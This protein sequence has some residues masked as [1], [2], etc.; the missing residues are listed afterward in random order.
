MPNVRTF[1]RSSGKRMVSSPPPLGAS[2]YHVRRCSTRCGVS[3]SARCA[4]QTI[5][6]GTYPPQPSGMTLGGTMRT[7]LLVDDDEFVL[8][9][10]S[11]VLADL[12]GT[13]ILEA[14]NGNQAIDVATHYHGR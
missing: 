13:H 10:C 8:R 5:G 9:L 1:E 4:S 2:D 7:V 12:R 6:A 14:A 3:A 11:S